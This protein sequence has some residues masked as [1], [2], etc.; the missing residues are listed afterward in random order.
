MFTLLVAL[1]SS[2]SA[3]VVTPRV[4]APSSGVR[5]GVPQMLTVTDGVDFDVIAREWRM[6]WSRRPPAP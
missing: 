6:K 1:S 4:S 3:L 5:T 2:A